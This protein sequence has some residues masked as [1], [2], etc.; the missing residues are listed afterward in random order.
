M[1]GGGVIT[2]SAVPRVRDYVLFVKNSWA[3]VLVTTALCAA[4]GWWS[5]HDSKPVYQSTASLFVRTEG[6]AT[7]LDAYYGDTTMLGQM[8]TYRQLAASAQVVSPIIQKLGLV[9]S[10][11]ELAGRILVLPSPDAVLNVTVT[12]SDPDQTSQIAHEVVNNMA[13]VSNRLAVVAGTGTTIAVVDD[14]GPA[15]R[16]G[17]MWSVIL[18]GAVLGFALCLIAVIARALIMGQVQSRKHLER[19]VADASIGSAR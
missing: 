8:E 2:P 5:W 10:D 18:T 17:G 3:L 11:K 14:A 6:S 1:C 4:V 13:A 7:P 9:E 19:V 15:D 16:V 12:G